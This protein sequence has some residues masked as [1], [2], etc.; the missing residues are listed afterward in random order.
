MTLPSEPPVRANDLVRLFLREIDT[1]SAYIAKLCLATSRGDLARALAASLSLSQAWGR[2]RTVIFALES[3]SRRTE[4]FA[5]DAVQHSIE[6]ARGPLAQAWE[7]LY[8]NEQSGMGPT[9]EGQ[10]QETSTSHETARAQ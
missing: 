6:A 8:P 10:P 1:A 9:A 7:L 3:A 4:A 2:A 5:R